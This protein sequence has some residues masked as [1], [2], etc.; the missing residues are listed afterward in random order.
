MFDIMRFRF[1][2]FLLS[3][4]VIVAGLAM[5]LVEPKLRWS[6]EFTAGTTARAVF[7]TPITADQVR[8]A[9]EP[10]GYQGTVVQSLGDREVFVR[11]PA[12]EQVEAQRT[13][14]NN[15]LK[16][17]GEV[18]AFD[19][20]TVSPAV[21]RGTV[22]KGAIAVGL[23]TVG[24]LIYILWAFRGVR[25]SFRW[26]VAA[27]IA[28]AHDL[29]MAFAI[30]AIAVKFVHL[31]LSTMFMVGILT[32]LGYSINDK[33]VIYDRVRENLARDTTRDLTSTVNLST[34]ETIGRSINTGFGVLLALLALWLLGPIS[35]R[36]FLL[37]MIVGVV[38]GTYSS[39]F[40][41]AALLVTW[42]TK[43]FGNV[44][45]WLAPWRRSAPRPAGP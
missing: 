21:A 17:L 25:H 36:D 7:A 6:I 9:I 37:V 11:L 33:I 42:D 15:A 28:L 8:T 2:Y 29:L 18:E 3:T 38:A 44:P 20:T 22:A 19:F 40:T 39:I 16:T 30:A 32:V 12:G 31:E 43:S 13:S 45:R 41:A 27:I 23:A 5:L 10:L 26:A 4:I 34:L 1:F 35:I 14:L 24:I